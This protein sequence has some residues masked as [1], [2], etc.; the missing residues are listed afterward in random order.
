MCVARSKAREESRVEGRKGGRERER[1][2]FN[3]KEV[4]LLQGGYDTLYT[5]DNL[6]FVTCYRYCFTFVFSTD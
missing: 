5:R 6:F 1:V 3:E 4:Y 2:G